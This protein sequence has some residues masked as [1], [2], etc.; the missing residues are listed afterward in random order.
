LAAGGLLGAGSALAACQV[1]EPGTAAPGASCGSFSEIHDLADAD[2]LL[3]QA[4]VMARLGVAKLGDAPLLGRYP[5]ADAPAE[6]AFAQQPARTI[7][8]I[9]P[10]PVPE[11]EGVLAA[12]AALATLGVLLRR[13]RSGGEAAPGTPSAAG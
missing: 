1:A 6:G 2:V 8:Q 3:G 10:S 11:P 7:A 9:V 5:Q 4:A 13:R 12:L